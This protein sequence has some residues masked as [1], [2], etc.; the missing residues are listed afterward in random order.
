VAASRGARPTSPAWQMEK[1]D[2]S[3]QS[4]SPPL[5]EVD[6]EWLA[7]PSAAAATDGACAEWS[8]S[9][10]DDARGGLPLAAPTGMMACASCS[11]AAT[12]GSIGTSDT[13]RP[14]DVSHWLDSA[15][16]ILWL[17]QHFAKA[18]GESK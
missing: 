2:S 4:C 13:C 9:S 14:C 8:T 15:L 16:G 7:T 11:A 18:L 10:A 1:V 6:G 3:F 17:N 5:N 12:G